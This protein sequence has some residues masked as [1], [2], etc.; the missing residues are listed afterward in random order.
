MGGRSTKII[1]KMKT[2]KTPRT[3]AAIT[4]VDVAFVGFDGLTSAP[5]FYVSTEFARE[6]EL[7]N[8]ELL[9][10]LNRL[11][12]ICLGHDGM[13]DPPSFINAISKARNIIEKYE[14]KQKS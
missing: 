7:E 9:L 10:T 5:E 11:H 1:I 14:A 12:R 2:S 6:L 4:I 8:A 13:I 3:D